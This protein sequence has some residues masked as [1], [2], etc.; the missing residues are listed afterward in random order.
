MSPF[1]FSYLPYVTLYLYKGSCCLP[2]RH[3]SG[4]VKF[5]VKLVC[6]LFRS[7]NILLVIITVLLFCFRYVSDQNNLLEVE[8]GF[9]ELRK[10]L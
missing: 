2:L 4:V 10:L 9:E 1:I 5:V 8:R 7:V 6:S 3:P